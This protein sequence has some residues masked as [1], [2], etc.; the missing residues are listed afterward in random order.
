LD[1]LNQPPDNVVSGCPAHVVA[2]RDFRTGERYCL[3]VRYNLH[4]NLTQGHT[5]KPPDIIDITRNKAQER[6]RKQRRED[7]VDELVLIE[8]AELWERIHTI[9]A[10]VGTWTWRLNRK[11]TGRLRFTGAENSTSDSQRDVCCVSQRRRGWPALTVGG[12]RY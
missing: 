9:A 12:T 7:L 2:V 1:H 11:V 8:A 6:L 3:E 4:R 5:H 10:R